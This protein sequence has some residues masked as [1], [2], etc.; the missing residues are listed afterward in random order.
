MLFAIRTGR[1]LVMAMAFLFLTPPVFADPC[2]IPLPEPQFGVLMSVPEIDKK[3]ASSE[4]DLELALRLMEQTK[5]LEKTEESR[6]DMYF[7]FW[8]ASEAIRMELAL[9]RRF[10]IRAQVQA[11]LNLV[12]SELAVG[13]EC[14]DVAFARRRLAYRL[15]PNVRTAH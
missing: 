6:K 7:Q 2:G 9:L 3:I 15:D 14:L 10:R 1:Y 12:L 5:T 11:A 8:Q 13:D 4:E